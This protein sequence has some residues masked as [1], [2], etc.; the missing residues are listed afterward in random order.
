M[1]RWVLA[2]GHWL[3]LSVSD[4]RDRGCEGRGIAGRTGEGRLMRSCGSASNPSADTP[5]GRGEAERAGGGGD[6]GGARKGGQP[7]LGGLTAALPHL[8]SLAWCEPDHSALLSAPVLQARRR[9][10]PC[11]VPHCSC[12]ALACLPCRAWRA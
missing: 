6:A 3:A 8:P 11:P 10:Q 7:A 1:T 4:A 9:R 5:A 12:P 2:A